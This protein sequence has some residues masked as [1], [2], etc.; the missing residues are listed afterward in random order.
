MATNWRRKHAG[1][2]RIS[3]YCIVPVTRKTLLH[4]G[5]LEKDVELLNKPYSRLELARRIRE[6]LAEG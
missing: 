3:R 6:V 4:H 5:L 2:T 1:T